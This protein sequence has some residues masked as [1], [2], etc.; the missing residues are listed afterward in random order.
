MAVPAS[1]DD[2][3][4][5]QDPASLQGQPGPISAPAPTRD[6]QPGQNLALPQRDQPL[7]SPSVPA[8][9]HPLPH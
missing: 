4:P 1:A 3:K 8:P 9:Y 7:D 2:L 6:L 5:L